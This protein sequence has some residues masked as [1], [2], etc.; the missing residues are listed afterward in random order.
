MRE[1]EKSQRS[2]NDRR[3]SDGDGGSPAPPRMADRS[4]DMIDEEKLP[5]VRSVLFSVTFPAHGQGTRRYTR[6]V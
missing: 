6:I 5:P 1:T 2:A 3:E 4:D